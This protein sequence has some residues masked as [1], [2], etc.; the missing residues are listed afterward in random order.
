M[1]V[2]ELPAPKPP[3]EVMVRAYEPFVGTSFSLRLEP[4]T[5][6]KEPESPPDPMP[7]V[8][9]WLSRTEFCAE[10]PPTIPGA[11]SEPIAVSSKTMYQLPRFWSKE[12]APANMPVMSVTRETSQ[13]ERSPLKESA[14]RNICRMLATEEVFQLE[15]SPSNADEAD[16]ANIPAM[17]VTPETSQLEMSPLK[18]GL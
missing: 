16:T 18:E 5:I 7:Y 11:S 17:S 6:S 8:G 12:A 1:I 2:R 9:R 3:V 15:R 13:E 14:L 4:L 10:M